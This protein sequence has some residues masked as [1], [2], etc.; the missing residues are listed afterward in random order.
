MAQAQANT[1]QTQTQEEEEKREIVSRIKDVVKKLGKVYDKIIITKASIGSK[2]EEGY[3]DIYEG[4][5]D[6]EE[7]VKDAWLKLH[8]IVKAEE[9]AEEAEEEVKEENDVD[10]VMEIFEELAAIYEKDIIFLSQYV[11]ELKLYE[12]FGKI[13]NARKAIWYA[14]L[15]LTNVVYKYAIRCS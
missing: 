10:K 8:A 7:N 3:W 5:G 4:M 15:G 2:V 13:E 12:Y 14:I 6:V 9:G 11:E 1:A